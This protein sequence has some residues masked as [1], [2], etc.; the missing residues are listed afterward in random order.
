MA[1]THKVIAIYN[2]KGG[3]GKTTITWALASLMRAEGYKVLCIDLDSQLNLSYTLGALNTPKNILSALVERKG[4]ENIYH[5]KT[6]GD[7][8]PG[9][10]NMDALTIKA[11]K[12]KQEYLLRELLAEI[13][14]YDVI[15]LDCSPGLGLENV[16]AL[17][18][19]DYLLVPATLETYA[20][21]GISSL[22]EVV[23]TIKARSNKALTWLGIV[24]TDYKPRLN[25]SQHLE[26][27]L[28]KMLN[29][30]NIPILHSHIRYSVKVKEAILNG[31]PLPEACNSYQDYKSLLNEVL[32]AMKI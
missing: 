11:R 23:K 26:N 5:V 29:K 6:W 16:N 31:E 14:G 30:E 12:S 4:R 24:I 2:Q 1:Q 13:E 7:I 8:I 10:V 15:L 19:A 22:L 32:E 3:V 20:L 17:T 25:L 27:Q 28:S 18:A 9:S 21:Q